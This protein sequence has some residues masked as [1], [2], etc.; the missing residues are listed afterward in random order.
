MW[1]PLWFHPKVMLTGERKEQEDQTCIGGRRKK[2]K[3]IMMVRNNNSSSANVKKKTKK[4]LKGLGSIINISFQT[5]GSLKLLD[6]ERWRKWRAKRE[7]E[8][9]S[10]CRN[11]AEMDNQIQRLGKHG[12]RYGTVIKYRKITMARPQSTKGDVA[13]TLWSTVT[14]KW[15]VN[16][17]RL[18][19][20]VFRF[21]FSSICCL[22]AL[23]THIDVPLLLGDGSW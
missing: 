20:V 17:S 2:M 18:S 6:R 15:F 8:K 1:T 5:R 7:R 11:W 12:Y 9:R 19:I 4:E 23:M 22:F 21:H 13:V 14:K 3:K 16:L 10:G